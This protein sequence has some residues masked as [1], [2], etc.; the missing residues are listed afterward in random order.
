MA[1]VG[2]AFVRLR[3]IG[4]RLASEIG[5]KVKESV[6]QAAPALDQAGEDIGT[7]V[8]DKVG[9]G[10]QQSVGQQ[11]DRIADDIGTRIGEAMAANMGKSLRRRMADR[12]R[13]GTSGLRAEA[14]R[15]GNILS[16]TWDQIGDIWGSRTKISLRKALGGLTA[17]VGGGLVAAL[18]SI[19]A[20]AGAVGGALVAT[21]LPAIASLGPAA[22]GA[23]IAFLA[24][25]SAMKISTGLLGLALKQNTPALED[26]KKRSEAFKTS[27]A[28]PVQAGLLS[29]L[30]AAMRISQPTVAGLQTQL[31]T[32]GV[33]AGDMAIRMADAFRQPENLVRLQA[34]LANSNFLL[35]QGGR[36]A[37]SLAQAFLVLLSHLGPVTNFIGELARDI[38]DW[39]L[40]ATLA[41]EATGRLDSFISRMFD[42]LRRFV[43]ILVDFGVGVWNVMRAASGAS[44]GMLL[45][46]ENVG[47]RFREWTGDEANQA[48]MTTFFENMR[49]ITG[50]VLGIVRD[51]A[52]TSLGALE[53]TDV[54]SVING[55]DTLRSFG[56]PLAQMFRDIQAASGPALLNA[57]Q[58]FA[59]V[60]SQLAASG[61]IGI[62]AGAFA[63]F[64]QIVSWFLALPLVGPILSFV[65]GLAVLARTF[66]LVMMA[67]NLLKPGFAILRV[68][69]MALV[70]VFGW[71]PVVIGVVVAA[72]IWFFTQTETGRAIVS[73]VWGAIKTAISAAVDGIVAAWNWMVAAFQSVWAFISTIANGIW[74][75]ITTAFNAV[76]GVVSTA[77][78]AVWTVVT[79]VWGAIWG[80]LQPILSGIWS[81]IQTVFTGI[82]TVIQTG[83]NI[84]LTIWSFVWPLLALPIRVLYGVI[85]FLFTQIWAGVQAIVEALWAFLVMAWNAIG[86][87][88]SASVS[89]IWGVITTVWNAI[90]GFLQPIVQAIW[91]FIVGAWNAI[92]GAISGAL[93]AIWGV[94]VSVWGAVSGFISGVLSAIGG[95][96]SNVWN[97]IVGAIRGAMSQV[98]SIIQSVW[99]NVVGFVEG[100]LGRIRGI[101]TNIWGGLESV[102]SGIVSGLKSAVN[103]V[104]GAVNTAI[105]GINSAIGVANMLPGPDIPTIPR[106]PRL[107]RGGTV[108]P[109]GG[110]TLA[111]VAEA[112]RPERIEPLDP[113]GLSRR[114]R[115]MIN[116]LADGSRGDT[117]VHVYLGTREIED[118]IDVVVEDREDT[119]ADRVLTGTKG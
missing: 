108:M 89:F 96:V 38:G 95:V 2:T 52:G 21:I 105:G 67:V 35:D 23:G 110:G 47:R 10:V 29:G 66:G 114:D 73:A 111:L 5:D 28:T 113:D 70:G 99:N 7:R 31:T 18:P 3:V 48:R 64:F 46:L 60:I 77:L 61:V 69:I 90:W 116:V 55:L 43:G 54:T 8:G 32:L 51:L 13:E 80:F 109:T 27:I 100:A 25:F 87:A 103:G 79:S 44:G 88:I 15:V 40:R 33:V 75:V 12:F 24:A 53:N 16:G 68:I 107:A 76:V 1:I 19:I 9:D 117:D 26:F 104:I 78:T 6:V 42:G 39:V 49:R 102:G 17:V 85:I 36:G 41:A 92:S 84:I 86:A 45:T 82:V 50:E 101:V 30:N 97:G 106:I 62:L 91:G 57:L 71:I 37:T 58:S 34:V 93:S 98:W 65:A 4:D 81:F 94:I 11:M 20:F 56:A 59:D 83:L 22:A 115:A 119:L 74:T 112:G 63:N 72:L 14:S 118:I